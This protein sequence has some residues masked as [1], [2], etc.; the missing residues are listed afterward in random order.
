MGRESAVLDDMAVNQVKIFLSTNPKLWSL[1]LKIFQINYETGYYFAP[2]NLIPSFFGY[3]FITIGKELNVFNI[4]HAIILILFS[5]YLIFSLSR[6]L[7][8]LRKTNNNLSILLK[9][10]MIL[11]VFLLIVLIFKGNYWSVVRLYS[12]SPLFLYL[13]M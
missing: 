1:F 10:F 2:V 4:L 5:I 12:Y 7:N 9:S 3:Y 11:F 6:N 13:F 8:I